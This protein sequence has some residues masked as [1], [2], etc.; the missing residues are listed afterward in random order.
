MQLICAHQCTS[1]PLKGPSLR[2]RG[3][4]HSQV[5]LSGRRTLATPHMHHSAMR[6]P[7]SDLGGFLLGQ[8]LAR[9]FCATSKLR[10]FVEFLGDTVVLYSIPGYI[11]RSTS[12]AFPDALLPADIASHPRPTGRA[13]C[14]ASPPAPRLGNGDQ[15]LLPPDRRGRPR[16]ARRRAA[17]VRRGSLP[18]PGRV[19][20]ST[21]VGGPRQA[22]PHCP[23][24]RVV[25]GRPPGTPVSKRAV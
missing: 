1:R 24:F 10:Q 8:S 23:D 11:P 2:D 7:A 16:H 19:G 13:P 5:A 25:P 22:T 4:L 21:R 12:V 3:W 14:G 18:W 6:V 17:R 9:H 20:A 15:E